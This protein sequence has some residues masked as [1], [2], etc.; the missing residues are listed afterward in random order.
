M[1]V[2]LGGWP[3]PEPHVEF[4]LYTPRDCNFVLAC[5]SLLDE[6]ETRCQKS[7][8]H[9]TR[10]LAPECI[11]WPRCLLPPPG[12]WPGRSPTSHHSHR[13]RQRP[14]PNARRLR[15]PRSASPR[16]RRRCPHSGLCLPSW[17]P[18]P[19]PAPSPSHPPPA[20]AAR[21]RSSPSS[22]QRSQVPR[23]A[24]ARSPTGRGCRPGRHR[25]PLTHAM[26]V[27]AKEA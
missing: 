25:S 16:P 20:E 3:N 8:K 22:S 5:G 13:R 11:T 4:T 9:T 18:S 17:P 23:P 10:R 27:A 24:N 7:A 1:S 26:E 6:T 12:A 14:R 21:R 2:T 19:P 15:S